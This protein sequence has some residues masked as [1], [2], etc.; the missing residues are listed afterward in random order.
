MT[1]TTFIIKS[2]FKSLNNQN[3]LLLIIAFICTFPIIAQEDDDPLGTEVVNIVKPY[4]PTISDAFKIKETPVLNDSISEQKKQ[5]EYSIFSV[6]V[7]STFTPSKGKAQTVEKAKKIKLFDNY[8]TLGFGNYTTVLGELY[9]NFQ[10][11]RTDNVGVFFSHNS[12]MGDIDDVKASTDFFDTQLDLSYSS[13]Q[14]DASYGLDVGVEHQSYNWYG[15]NDAFNFQPDAFFDDTDFVQNYFSGY[16]GGTIDVEN[17]FFDKATAKLRYLSDSYESS[18]INFTAMPEFAFPVADNKF[19]IGIDLD[20][21][22]GSFYEG[23]FDSETQNY[24]QFNAGI[25]PSIDIITDDLSLSLGAKVYV[26]MDTENSETD[27]YVYPNVLASYSVVDEL[28]I[29]YAG[30]EGGL[31]QNTFYDFKEVNPFISPTLN[32]APTSKNYDAFLGLKGKLSSAIAYNVRGSYSN[33]NDKS[34]FKANSYTPSPLDTEGYKYG[35]SFNV[36]YD[37]INTLSFFGELKAEISPNFNIGVNGTFNSYNTDN[38]QE[39]WNLPS[40]QATVFSTFNITEALYGGVSLFYVG[41]R[42]DFDDN[43]LIDNIVADSGVVTLDGY[44]DANVHV[45][46][47]LSER[48]SIFMKGSNLIGGNYEKWYNYPVQGI[49]VL[50]GA[51]YKFDW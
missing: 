24:S 36:I 25:L 30:I 3:V 21:L 43:L 29:A 51:T 37:D 33:E 46:Y 32:I 22:S 26:G 16:I 4:T 47:R 15:I 42:K 12:A 49:Q 31:T 39:A 17:S 48:L 1:S 50:G 23:L 27:F 5:V 34:L 14:R 41:E 40:L 2:I 19:K 8:A 7:A 44:V 10:L 38:Q 20:Y 9:S 6:P 35:N 45:G 11:S 18:E 13:R 28:V